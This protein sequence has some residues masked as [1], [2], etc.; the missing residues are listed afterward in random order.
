[1]RIERYRQGLLSL[2]ER[3]PRPVALVPTMG[4][5]HEGHL[6]LVRRA[7]ELG[8]TVVVSLFVNPLQFGPSE[9]FAEYPRT[10]GRDTEL[11]GGLCDILFA[12]PES[13]VY[14]EE[15][16]V[17]IRLPP[18]A[19]D[20]CGGFRP[21][22]FEGVA[23]VVAKL[24]NLVRPD[25]A[26]FGKKDYQ[27]AVL[28]RRMARQLSYPVEIELCDTVR[29]KDGLAM[30]SRNSYL[31]PSERKVAAAVWES[32]D[33]VGRAIER[34]EPPG[35]IAD[36]CGSRVGRLRELGFA[37]D[38]LEVRDEELSPPSYAAGR[39]LLALCAAT[40]GSCRL[41]DNREAVYASR[42]G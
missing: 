11:L 40:I 25:V 37:P 30:S 2:L 36:L 29:E 31:S 4:G 7:R 38:Y 16:S 23:V 39:R 1:M 14:P 15:Q 10:F 41:I 6:S 27:Q 5:L 8:R 13:E 22:F 33:L 28:V 24:L 32:V 18:L 12:P 35:S 42:A 21:G 17:G 19:G 26:L 3:A 20:L 9:D 34:G